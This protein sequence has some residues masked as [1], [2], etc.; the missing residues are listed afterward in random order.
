M[1]M[2]ALLLGGCAGGLGGDRPRARV[3]GVELVDVEKEG[4]AM[5]VLLE[6]RNGWGETL[7][8]EE[9]TYTVAVE[10]AGT[11]RFVTPVAAA[12]PARGWGE[13]PTDSNPSASG[14]EGGGAGMQ[15]VRLGAAVPVSGAAGESLV[16]RR[17]RVSGR[18]TYRPEGELAQI[19]RDTGVPRPSVGFDR[20]VRMGDANGLQ[21]VGF[22]GEGR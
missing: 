21:S 4:A 16:G 7:P 10:N 22:E 19:L 18:L 8:L 11:R 9:A 3:V 17:V 14:G 15:V 12:V 2:V 13:K 20:V 5:S 1:V 6:V